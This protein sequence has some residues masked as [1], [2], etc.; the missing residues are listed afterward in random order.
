MKTVTIEQASIDLISMID[1]SL[2]TREEINIATKNGAV[3]ILPQEDYEAM[4]ET[5]RLLMDKR[6]FQALIDGQKERL[7]GRIPKSYSFEEIF[8]DL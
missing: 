5:L 4:Q 2:K 3:I 8:N 7:E 6:S 1:Y